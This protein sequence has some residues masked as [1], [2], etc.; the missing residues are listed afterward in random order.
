MID[1]T[2]TEEQQLLQKT[3]RDF[4]EKEIR[5]VAEKIEQMG[6]LS[7]EETWALVEGIF[8]KAVEIGFTT[9]YIPERYG[10]GGRGPIDGAIISEELAAADIGIANALG[11][12]MGYPMFI[13]AAGTEEQRQ[14]WLPEMCSGE[15]HVMAGAQSEPNVAGSELFCPYPDPKLGLK[16]VARRDGDEYVISGA[17]SAFITNAGVA[18]SYFLVCRTDLTRPPAESMS[19]FYVPAD[20]PGFSVG[21]RTHM[22]GMKT[23]FHAELFLD[24]VRVPKECLLGR[25]GEALSILS[26]VLGQGLG[27]QFVGLARAAYQ[28]ALEYAKQRTSWGQ[29][30]IKHQAVALKLADMEIEIQA[31]RLLSWDAACAAQRLD[32]AA[33]IKGIA[34]KTY[35]VDIAIKTAENAVKILG[36]YGVTKEYKTAKYMCD[37]LMGYACD[38]TGDLLRLR[39]ADSL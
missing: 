2:L 25:E 24:D 27:I 32:P 33:G 28:Y 20:L 19:L 5:P 37:A 8:K 1:F 26:Q 11:A 9:L 31:A 18:K 7:T 22:L 16:T 4:A 10:G 38:F 21:K 36:A 15:V 39:I 14:R 13:V 17:K 34:S 23:G 6:E 29:P 12:V 3:A 30:L 35:A